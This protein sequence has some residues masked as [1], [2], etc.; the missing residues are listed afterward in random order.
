[1][2]RWNLIVAGAI[3]GFGHGQCLSFSN[4]WTILEQII[5]SLALNP[6]FKVMEYILARVQTKDWKILKYMYVI[7]DNSSWIRWIYYIVRKDTHNQGIKKMASHIR[8]HSSFI[9]VISSALLKNIINWILWIKSTSLGYTTF[10]TNDNF[11]DLGIFFS[12]N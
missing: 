1:M 7:S 10:I 9:S 4:T 12:Q 11:S 5:F 6:V 2:I 3:D 8:R